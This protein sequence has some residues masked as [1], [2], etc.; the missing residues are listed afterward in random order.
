VRGT[1][2]CSG[3]PT[4]GTGLVRARAPQRRRL[5]VRAR[6]LRPDDPPAEFRYFLYPLTDEELEDEREAHRKFRTYVGTHCDYDANG[7]IDY[8]GVECYD[9]EKFYF[10]RPILVRIYLSRPPIAWF[11]W[12]WARGGTTSRRGLSLVRSDWSDA[13][14]A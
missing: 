10:D 14:I 12:S 8:S 7:N 6:R 2:G 1:S 3:T 9:P 13:Q 11:T 4:T 5:L